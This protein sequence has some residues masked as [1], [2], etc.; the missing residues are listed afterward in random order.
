MLD[1]LWAPGRTLIVCVPNGASGSPKRYPSSSLSLSSGSRR[2]AGRRSHRTC[3][4][5]DEVVVYTLTSTDF[6][7]RVIGFSGRGARNR[8]DVEIVR[9]I[10]PSRAIPGETITIRYEIRNTGETAPRH[11]LDRGCAIR[12]RRASEGRDR[13]AAREGR[14]LPVR[15]RDACSRQRAGRGSR[16]GS[17]PRLLCRT[18]RAISTR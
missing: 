4:R 18:T 12:T 11:V 16:S 8:L 14:T 6:R 9:V 5:G 1:I 2:P 13:S 7:R 3:A 10:E 17:S 15:V